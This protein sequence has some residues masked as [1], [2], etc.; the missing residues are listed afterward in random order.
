MYLPHTKKHTSQPFR[1]NPPFPPA[2]APHPHPTP[3]CPYSP[4]LPQPHP[5][6]P[7]TPPRPP[8]LPAHPPPPLPPPLPRR[9]GDG[10]LV[11]AIPTVAGYTAHAR[12]APPEH[13]TPWGTQMVAVQHVTDVCILGRGEGRGEGGRS[14]GVD[15][16]HDLDVLVV[17]CGLEICQIHT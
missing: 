3:L 15:S 5:N 17:G 2:S 13:L 12:D 6:P 4:P 7:Q 14:R 16:A 9:E 10:E 1:P 8:A 11:G